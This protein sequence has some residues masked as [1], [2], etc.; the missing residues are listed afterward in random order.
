MIWEFFTDDNIEG[1]TFFNL[2]L[3]NVLISFVSDNSFS[4][5]QKQS[6]TFEIEW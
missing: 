1:I 6:I 2:K 3:A 4:D 5:K